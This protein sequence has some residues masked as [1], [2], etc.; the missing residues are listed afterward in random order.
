MLS[1][2]QGLRAEGF[3]VSMVK[4]CR[5]VSFPVKQTFQK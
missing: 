5:C 1:I 2:Q 4:L 3:E